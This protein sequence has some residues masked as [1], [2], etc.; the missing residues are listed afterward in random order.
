M[1]QESE[2]ERVARNLFWWH[3]PELA[4]ANPRRILAQVMTLGAWQEVQLVQKTFGW[5]A[6][7]DALSNAPAGVFDGRSWAYWRAFF[8]LPEAELPR[9]SLK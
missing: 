5:D 1:S 3:E 6:F 4:L 9:R 8:G 7:K 2:L